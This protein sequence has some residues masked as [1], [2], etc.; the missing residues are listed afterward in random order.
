MEGRGWLSCCGRSA[1]CKPLCVCTPCQASDSGSVDAKT[2]YAEYW[3]GTHPNGPSSIQLKPGDDAD[4]TVD[5]KTW[6]A[7]RAVASF[8]PLVVSSP[9]ALT[10]RWQDRA[11]QRSW[12]ALPPRMAPC[13]T[14]SRSSPSPRHCLFRYTQSTT[15]IPKSASSHSRNFFWFVTHAAPG[16][17]EQVVGRGAAQGA[18]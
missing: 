14:S 15:A 2:P 11:T 9:R 7:V 1:R 18:P 8:G 12:A 4:A 13:P 3:F 17:P 16:T 6:L 5:L 10:M